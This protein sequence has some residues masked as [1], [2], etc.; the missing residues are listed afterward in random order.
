M[1]RVKICGITCV[2]DA[3]AALEAGA[4]ALGFVFS[5]SP[6]RI[7][8]HEART[9][10]KR[11]PPY[12]ARVGVFVNEEPKVVQ[13]VAAL[14]LL[15]TVQLHGDEPP[16]DI[17]KLAGLKIVKAFR[18]SRKED[19]D[20]IASYKADAFL[21]DSR[22]KGKMG[23]TGKTF[24]WS[25]CEAAKSHGPLVLSGGLSCDNVVEAVERVKPYA[26]D[27]SSSVE[28]EP[29]RKDHALVR[30]FIELAKQAGTCS[31]HP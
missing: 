5:E 11:L 4:D 27:V 22:V 19:L 25:L 15:D 3:L 6:R 18:V 2:E 16:E 10:A 21:L 30:R 29:G 1:V 9:I 14:C 13:A 24:D 17:P 7:N 12:A 8:L 31:H 23:G 26:V 28:R 20:G